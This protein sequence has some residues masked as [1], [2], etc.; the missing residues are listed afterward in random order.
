MILLG[1]ASS[2]AA[3]AGQ[4][5]RPT[6]DSAQGFDGE[7]E[8]K[9][10]QGRPSSHRADLAFAPREIRVPFP[11]I[12]KSFYLTIT[13]LKQARDWQDRPC[14]VMMVVRKTDGTIEWMDVRKPLKQMST[15]GLRTFPQLAF[16]GEPLTAQSLN[17]AARQAHPSARGVTP[18][19]VAANLACVRVV[20]IRGSYSVRFRT[21]AVPGVSRA[22]LG[23]GQAATVG[24]W[25]ACK[26]REY[27]D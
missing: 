1:H 4:T 9:D 21:G 15:L 17:Q 13:D 16:R 27:P 19:P 3:E 12:T 25:P 5:F 20:G 6:P 11:E 14:P 23:G 24:T 26:I 8:F 10:H 22:G 18:D 7:L 2:V